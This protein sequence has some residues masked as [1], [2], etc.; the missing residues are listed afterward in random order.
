MVK[1]VENCEKQHFVEL[2]TGR[3]VVGS[4]YEDVAY[5]ELNE[6]WTVWGEE[7]DTKCFAY[8]HVI[9]QIWVDELKIKSFYKP[10]GAGM[11]APFG[12]KGDKL[13]ELKEC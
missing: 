1:S 10:E 11:W 3:V 2:A 6:V 7:E 4:D 12:M 13:Q 9:P 8:D 5:H